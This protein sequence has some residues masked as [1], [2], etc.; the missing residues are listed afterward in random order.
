M[1]GDIFV[2]WVSLS[3][4]LNTHMLFNTKNCLVCKV[5]CSYTAGVC[6]LVW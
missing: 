1:N 5:D 6:Y 4:S 3:L 2:R